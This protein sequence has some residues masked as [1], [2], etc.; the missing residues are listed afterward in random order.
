MT[1]DDPFQA[2]VIA[3]QIESYLDNDEIKVENLKKLNEE[4]LSA[5]DGQRIS[6]SVTPQII[7]EAGWDK[8]VEI[9]DSGSYV[10]YDFSTA[11]N[12]L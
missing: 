11:S 6:G 1:V 10:R 7:L 3:A 5:L 2:N 12:L 4:L 9:L 8:S